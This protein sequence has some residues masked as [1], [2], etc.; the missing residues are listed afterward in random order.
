MKT[1]LR[2]FRMFTSWERSAIY[3]IVARFLMIECSAITSFNVYNTCHKNNYKN[4]DFQ[5]RPRAKFVI[6]WM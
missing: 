6:Y 2:Y 1:V 4:D 3:L 5:G